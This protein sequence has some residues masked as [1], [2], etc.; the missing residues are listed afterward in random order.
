MTPFSEQLKL[1]PLSK[2][3]SGERV[4]SLNLEPPGPFVVGRSSDAR[5]AIPDP[6]VSRRHASFTNDD[7]TWFL[8]DLSS[9]HGTTINS[10]P[11]EPAVPMPIQPGDV[12]K[13]G[14]W[15]CR[16][17]SGSSHEGMTTPFI[18]ALSEEESISVIE[19]D[20]LGGV[21]QRGLDVLMEL[22][23]KLHD[24]DERDVLA[25]AAVD[26]I[27][28][29]TGCRRVVI[30]EPN[31]DEDLVVIASTSSDSPSV[32]RT[33]IEQA[34]LK[35][36]VELTITDDPSQQAH[37]IMSLGIRS[38]L[39]A[40]I[41]V[42]NSPVAFLMIDTRDAERAVPADAAAFCQSVSRLLGVAF[43]RI[44]NAKMAERH[45]QLQADLDTARRAQ[46]LLSPPSSGRF[47]PVQYQVESIPGRV[48][49]GDLFDIFALDDSRTAFFLGDVSGKGVGAAMLM[50]ACQSQLRTQLLS[51]TEL[52]EALSAVNADLHARSDSSKFVT[53]IAAVFDKKKEVV[54]LADAGHGFAILQQADGGV[55]RVETSPGFPLG[56]V[57][58]AEYDTHE[59]GVPEGAGL[60]L[61]SDGAVEQPD[62]DG[63]QFGF[64]RI[65]ASMRL[66]KSPR[67]SVAALIA[68]V[69]IYAAGPLADDLTV[70]SIWIE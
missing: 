54:T 1:C 68:D 5:W 19:Q 20:Q 43:E 41:L 57:E 51:G 58:S 7:A 37:S 22:T 11:I 17:V 35:G 34:S 4:Q 46:E 3:E 47:G 59:V 56:V 55:Q 25:F 66:V 61:F 15:R 40:P 23:G 45:K 32:S 52:A 6:S 49:A 63:V 65:L 24:S 53:L 18:S 8:T 50:A 28:E 36:L 16:C 14:A 70:A 44:N 33:L 9:R 30:V 38:A 29:A 12:I 48:V 21:A 62:P 31:T 27:R 10:C 13:F 42:E 39:C 69:Q 64:E 60:L 67:D 26:G 2:I